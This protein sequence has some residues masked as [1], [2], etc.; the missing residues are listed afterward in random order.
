MDTR[1][2]FLIKFLGFFLFIALIIETFSYFIIRNDWI[3]KNSP[4]QSSTSWRLF[5][6]KNH[7]KNQALKTTDYLIDAYHPI[8]G[9]SPLKNTTNVPIK[10]ALVNIN[11]DGIRGVK[12]YPLEK[13]P[14]NIRIALFGDSFSFGEGVNDDETYAALLEKT[15]PNTEIIN[16]SVHGYGIDQMSLRLSLDGFKYNPD[17]VLYAFISDDID[18]VILNFRDYA[19]PKYELKNNELILSNTP[20]PNP[21]SLSEYYQHHFSTPDAFHLFYEKIIFRNNIYFNIEP[22]VNA[23]WKKTVVESKNHNSI[24]IFLYLP[25][26]D[27]MNDPNTQS[28][29]E[30]I[31]FSFCYSEKILCFSARNYF[32]FAYQNGIRFNPLLH[33]EASTH[34]IIASSLA[35]DLKNSPSLKNF[36]KSH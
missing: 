14:Q 6:I 30:K 36:W 27:E 24:P 31:M 33:Y 19:K 13:S 29:T 34:K 16:F 35:E 18:R 26:G 28:Y 9:W 23:I 5:W 25:S 1:L 7:Q 3:I 17:I 20:L 4:R 12:N 8:L 11:S 10:G 22:L 15:L 32:S 2:K 21:K